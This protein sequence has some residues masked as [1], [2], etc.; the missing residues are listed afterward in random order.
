MA[1][2]RYAALLVLVA[3]AGCR[4]SRRI[5]HVERDEL[6]RDVAFSTWP[7]RRV[8][9]LA[10]SNTE[11]LFAIGAGATVVGAD[12]YA[13]WPA[14]VT[15]VPRVG[16]QQEPSVEAVLGL[17]PDVV[18]SAMSANRQSTV[19]ALER[20]GFSPTVAG[21]RGISGSSPARSIPITPLPRYWCANSR[22]SFPPG[23]WYSIARLRGNIRLS[24]YRLLHLWYL[25][26]QTTHCKSL[27]LC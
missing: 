22:T 19:E 26:E 24:L 15:A 9:S 3:L 4:G 11:I 1:K 27:C 21:E 16:T 17:R 7:A 20:L 5:A 18:V 8:V 10:T 14:A 6:G 13:N 12:V 25:T 2:T 23:I